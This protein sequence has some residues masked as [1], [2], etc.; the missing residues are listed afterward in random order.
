VNFFPGFSFGFSI[1][2]GGFGRVGSSH[3]MLSYAAAWGLAVAANAREDQG[4]EWTCERRHEMP[5]TARFR[6]EC[7]APARRR[8]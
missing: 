2:G 3:A 7:G 6:E 8:T 1:A 5:P 4:I